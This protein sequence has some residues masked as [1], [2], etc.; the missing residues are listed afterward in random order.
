[1]ALNLTYSGC[2]VSSLSPT[3]SINGC[4]CDQVCHVFQDCCS[5]VTDIGCYPVTSSSTSSTPTSSMSSLTTSETILPTTST[6][7]TSET[8]LPPTSTSTTSVTSL[9]PTSTSLASET[10]LLPTSTSTTSVTSLPPTSTST[11]SETPPPSTITST[12]SETI[13]T[14][15]STSITSETPVAPTSIIT[16]STTLSPS[17][18]SSPSHLCINNTVRINSDRVVEWCVKG[19]WSPV[20]YDSFW[21]YEDVI[22]LCKELGLEWSGKLT[23]RMKK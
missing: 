21:N 5:D 12:D 10:P 17:P 8:P 9:P 2:C 13:I 4:W 11:T 16:T 6:S 7:T 22:V 18:S 14:P 3:C 1:M 23:G 15:T 20:C 19:E